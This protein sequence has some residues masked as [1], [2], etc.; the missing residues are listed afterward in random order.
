MARK[1]SGIDRA[2]YAKKA[3]TRS[4]IESLYMAAK[5]PNGIAIVHAK[6]IELKER[7]NV[8]G[9]RCFNKSNTSTL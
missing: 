2:A 1:N 7:I 6:R 5:I 3:D 4:K 9:T 8:A